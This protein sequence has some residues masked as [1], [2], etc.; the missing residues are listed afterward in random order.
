MR[1]SL[2]WLADLVEL[3][4]QREL[5]DRLTFAG[6]EVEA[7]EQIGAGLEQVVVAQILASE[8]H[9]KADRLSV[10]T[11]DAGGEKL[12]IVCGAKNYRVGDKVPLARVGAVL[13]DG[14]KIEAAKLRG[15]DSFGMLCSQK[16][17]AL[18]EDHEGLWILPANAD[19]GKPLAQALGLADTVFEINVTPNRADCLSHLGIA[20]EVAALFGR[21]LRVLRSPSEGKAAFA[22]RLPAAPTLA[23]PARCGRYLGQAVTGG[24]ALGQP[25]P[26]WM[27]ARLMACGV[28][29][30]GLA[31]DVTNY[32]LLELGQP[33]HAFDLSGITKGIEVRLAREGEKLRTLDGVD[34]TLSADDLLICDGERALGLAGVMGGEESGVTAATRSLYLE[35]AWFDPAGIRRVAKRH[36]LH[37]E[38]SHRF[39]RGVDPELPGRAVDR[40]IALLRQGVPDLAVAPLQS[41]DGQLPPK[42]WVGFRPERVKRLLGDDVPA[43]ESL[44]LLASI[45]LVAK[46]APS[47]TPGCEVPSYRFDLEHEADLIE[48]IARL[49]GYDRIPLS[50]P[51]RSLPPPPERQH[52]RALAAVRERLAACG[53]SEAV[54]YSF[55][56]GPAAAPFGQPAAVALQNPLKTEQALLR[57]SLLPGLCQNAKLNLAHLNQVAGVPPAIRLFE[58]G[59]VFA[60]PDAGERTE[61]PVR[62]RATIA[63]LAQ[64]ARTP[65]GWKSDREA[66]DFY[67][68]KGVLEA[69]VG[70]LGVSFGPAAA[71]FL[72]P[73]ARA[74]VLVDGKAIGVFGELHPSA[75]AALEL[76][77]GVFVAELDAAALFERWALPRFAGLPKFPAVLRDIALVVPEATDA[78]A[79]EA[80]LRAAGGSLLEGLVLFDVYRGAPLGE[81]QKSLAYSLQLRAPD[82]TLTDDEA[83]KVHEAIVAAARGQLGAELRG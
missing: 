52:H 68:L 58:T 2:N 30:L 72:H 63:L 74:N 59:R 34:R 37:T 28:R 51:S 78:A 66:F 45:G 41:A 32:V 24:A 64:G 54:N 5:S 83:G 39:E 50:L 76:P 46:A 82:R 31:I 47:K 14:H 44:R 57:S 12:Q 69:L 8:P 71:D 60:W 10:T 49:R 36:G 42:R 33:L 70:E 27:R 25:S 38:A 23:A 4:A 3:P 19:L 61:G 11:V 55:I 81:G 21:P 65:V 1:V 56:A 62:E 73:R 43:E 40:A 6:L 67:D 18:S 22:E 13:P 48:E 7:I 80:V 9:P 53:F 16:E 35:A 75:A 77:R 79:V 17:L 20:R 29:S 15:V 26:P